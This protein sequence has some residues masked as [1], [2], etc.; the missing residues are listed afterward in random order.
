MSNNTHKTAPQAVPAQTLNAK[1]SFFIAAL[2]IGAFLLSYNYAN[3]RT[4]DNASSAASGLAAG[5]GCGMS[6]GSGA[7][8]GG[9]CCGGGGTSAPVEGVTTE[10]AG[11]QKIAVDT[12]A[13]SFSPNVVKAKAGVPIEMTFSQAPGG[14]LSGVWFP[15]FNIQE[16]LTAGP[17]TVELPALEKGEYQFYC[18]MQ[19]I[20]AT[21]VVE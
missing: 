3:A 6:G 19:M 5:G 2:V 1:R 9:G 18:Q 15:D 10:E 21:L 14:C 4:P 7:A 17:K 13:G 8:G 11:I 12:S 16:D 20:S